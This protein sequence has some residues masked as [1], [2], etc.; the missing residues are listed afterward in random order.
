M[1]SPDFLKCWP[2]KCRTSF[3]TT[4][5]GQYLLLAWERVH[6]IA[7]ILNLYIVLS[8]THLYHFFPVSIHS[9]QSIHCLLQ[10]YVQDISEIGKSFF[11]WDEIMEFF[12]LELH[13]INHTNLTNIQL[14]IFFLHD[15]KVFPKD[16]TW[17]LMSRQNTIS[18]NTERKSFLFYF[19]GERKKLMPFSSYRGFNK[20]SLHNQFTTPTTTSTTTWSNIQ[21]N[22]LLNQTP[23]KK[24]L[25]NDT[26][27]TAKHSPNSHTCY[28][29]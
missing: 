8:C 23:W 15:F 13:Y 6:H 2:F 17:V 26:K 20:L 1:T 12:K 16:S 25:R 4:I 18:S 10:L 21:K 22:L 11:R 9:L 19:A 5:Y 29:C 24:K 14:T 27:I 28:H 7:K 3:S